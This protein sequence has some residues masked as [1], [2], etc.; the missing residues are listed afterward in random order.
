MV[1]AAVWNVPGHLTPHQFASPSAWAA[2]KKWASAHRIGRRQAFSSSAEEELKR[3]A[4]RPTTR[5]LASVGEIL[6]GWT[7]AICG[8]GEMMNWKA[9]DNAEQGPKS[10]K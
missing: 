2:A 4:H 9:V 6:K 1:T 5:T 10:C 3:S 7:P 8:A